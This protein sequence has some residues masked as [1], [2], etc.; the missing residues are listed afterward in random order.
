[1]RIYESYL[2][3]YSR[4]L[5]KEMTEEEKK[6]WYK[7]LRSYP[8]QFRRQLP[9]QQFI[10]DFYCSEA[11][12]AI[13]IDGSQHYEEEKVMSDVKRDEILSNLGIKVIRYNNRQINIEFRSVCE[14]IDRIVKSRIIDK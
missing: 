10:V 9:I 11:K 6:L 8:K 4:K 3:K 5:R 13:E 1:M 2:K 7:Y 14:D 12:L